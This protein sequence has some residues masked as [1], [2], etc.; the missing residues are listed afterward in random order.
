MPLR[1]QNVGMHIQRLESVQHLDNREEWVRE[2]EV[3]GIAPS[4]MIFKKF[5]PLTKTL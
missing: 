4:C 2:G 1:T 3:V 5:L